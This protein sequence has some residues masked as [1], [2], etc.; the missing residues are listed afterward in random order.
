MA[1]RSYT[2][3]RG[4][5]SYIKKPCYKRTQEAAIMKK[6][7]KTGQKSAGKKQK[8]LRKK[9]INQ[10]ESYY[11]IE[12]NLGEKLKQKQHKPPMKKHRNAPK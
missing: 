9:L 8:A 1:L 4:G 3:I 12:K 2:R 11:Q 5:E 7:K 10:L 6:K